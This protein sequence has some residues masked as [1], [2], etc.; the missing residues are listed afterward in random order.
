MAWTEITR[1]KYR[2]D[3]LRYASDTSDEEWAVIEPHLPPPARC[4]RTRETSLRD[5]VNAIFYIAQTGC[6]WRLLPKDFPRFTT[7]QRY[8]Y[9]WRDSGLWQTINHVLLMQVREA[10][11]REATPTAGVIDS[12][13]VK[14]T[15]SGGPRGYAAEKMIKGRKRHILTDTIGLPVGMIVH[16]ADVQDR[17]QVS[18]PYPDDIT[19]P[20]F[21]VDRKVEH[22]AVAHPPLAI[23]PKPNGP[24]LLRFQRLLGAYHPP[25][26]P[27]SPLL[28][29]RIILRMSHFR[30]LV[31]RCGRQEGSEL[32]NLAADLERP[33]ARGESCASAIRPQRK[34]P[35]ILFESVTDL[36]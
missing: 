8:F 30:P 16:P 3:G 25:G 2:R 19:A 21:A 23:Q 26:I 12:Q 10:A 32:A 33:R 17:D 22:G 5:V 28:T 34:E 31:G 35:D 27:R 4:G 14:T 24:D 13:S 9:P 6:Q 1:P 20:Q 11:G 7:V 29:C 36:L 15:E 18:D